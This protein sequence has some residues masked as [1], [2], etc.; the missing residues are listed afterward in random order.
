MKKLL[1]LVPGSEAQGGI[2]NYFNVLRPEFGTHITY[3]YR[4]NRNW[5]VRSNLASELFRAILDVFGFIRILVSRKFHIIQINTSLDKNSMI[6]DGLFAILC[7]IFLQKYI[8]FYRGWDLQDEQRIGDKYLRLFKFAFFKAKLSLVLSKYVE[9]VLYNWGYSGSVLVETTLVDANLL[10]GFDIN[11][12]TQKRLKQ[13]FSILFLA[14]IEIEKGIYELLEAYR[15]VKKS[16]PWI[17]LI[18]AGAGSE[19]ERVKKLILEWTLEDVRLFGYLRG[20]VKAKIYSEADLYVL[21]SYTEGMPNSVLEAMAFGLPIITTPVG[22]LTDFFNESMGRF[23]EIRCIDQI[24]S[25]IEEFI[26]DN[27]INIKISRFNYDYSKKYFTSDVV[28]K[29]LNEIYNTLL[30]N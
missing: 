29:R 24:R 26:K 7:R 6:R 23:V 27:E 8:V 18:I 2:V 14:R 13:S 4:G 9:Q 30:D 3:F 19:T 20:A 16:Y 28:A 10:S 5:P 25:A 1:I 12:R 11:H 15:S 21:P 22:G 17:S